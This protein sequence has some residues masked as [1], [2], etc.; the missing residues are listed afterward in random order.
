MLYSIS[1]AVFPLLPCLC[2]SGKSTLAE[3]FAAGAFVD[4]IAQKYTGFKKTERA[5]SFCYFISFPL[6]RP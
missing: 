3:T 2:Q 1:G 5:L 4:S 6:P